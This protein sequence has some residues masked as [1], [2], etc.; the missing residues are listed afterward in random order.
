[1]ECVKRGWTGVGACL[2]S[3][4][5]SK[6]VNHV[7]VNLIVVSVLTESDIFIDI[8][9]VRRSRCFVQKQI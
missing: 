7:F 5:K 4:I 8:F 3:L 6:A 9:M 2:H 1:M